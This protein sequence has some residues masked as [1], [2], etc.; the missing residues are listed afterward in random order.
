MPFRGAAQTIPAMLSGDVAFA[1]DNLA[2]Y[3]SNIE[4][5]KCAPSR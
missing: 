4:G 5:G 2:S 3:T 1:I